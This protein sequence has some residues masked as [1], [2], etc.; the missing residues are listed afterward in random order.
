MMAPES[1]LQDAHEGG[2]LADRMGA[3][4]GALCAI[5]C[6]ATIPLAGVMSGGMAAI[7]GHEAELLLFGIAGVLLVLSAAHGYR[8]HR[9]RGIVLAFGLCALTWLAGT[10]LAPEP[11]EGV[12]HLSAAVGLAAT[13]LVSLRRL[14]ACAH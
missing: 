1:Q 8:H 6:A 5:H 11:L 10:F 7:F 3:L 12:L 13:H 4:A 14:R 9:S 2:H